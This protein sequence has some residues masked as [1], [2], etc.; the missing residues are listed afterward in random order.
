MVI[1]VVKDF[2]QDEEH[3]SDTGDFDPDGGSHGVSGEARVSGCSFRISAIGELL[4]EPVQASGDSSAG[5]R[6][7]V[8]GRDD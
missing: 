7:A 6:L 8:S 1:D 4:G 5:E 3:Q 2:A